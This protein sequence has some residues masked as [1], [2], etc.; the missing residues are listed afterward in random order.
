MSKCIHK[1]QAV[2]RLCFLLIAAQAAY[3]QHSQIQ[4]SSHVSRQMLERNPTTHLQQRG[5]SHPSVSTVHQRQS[6]SAVHTRSVGSSQPQRH[7]GQ[8]IHVRPVPGGTAGERS[9]AH[10]FNPGMGTQR[11]DPSAGRGGAFRAVFAVGQRNLR[12]GQQAKQH[13]VD[14]PA[15]SGRDRPD[16]QTGRGGRGSRQQP[17]AAASQGRGRSNTSSSPDTNQRRIP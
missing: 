10:D 17:A 14:Q 16:L 2:L 13:L 7:A 6:D 5:G 15:S 3:G 8:S 11:P 9:G 4:Q 12:S 1:L